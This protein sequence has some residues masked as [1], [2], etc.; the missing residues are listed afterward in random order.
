MG[1]GILML[2][3]KFQLN[4]T[5]FGLVIAFLRWA[6]LWIERYRYIGWCLVWLSFV[7]KSMGLGFLKLHA[8]FQLNWTW[9]GWFIA[10]YRFGLVW[11]GLVW[12]S[13]VHKSMGLDFLKLYTKFQLNWTWFGW[14]IDNFRFGLVWLRFGLANFFSQIN[15]IEHTD[16][17]CKI[18]AQSDLI[19]LSYS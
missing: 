12:L 4:R 18:S 3:A 5:W 6:Q 14:V 16:A 7:H 17:A 19:W 13:L 15:G 2:H 10:I 9:F 11:L 8:K 1:L